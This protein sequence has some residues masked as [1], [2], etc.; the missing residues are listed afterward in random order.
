MG[1]AYRH[2]P[3]CS[4]IH[5]KI[6]VCSTYFYGSSSVH[7]NTQSILFIPCAAKFKTRISQ[8]AKALLT[9]SRGVGLVYVNYGVSSGT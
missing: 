7:Q 3:V 9:R 8:K 6:A 2:T 4:G 5:N 1:R